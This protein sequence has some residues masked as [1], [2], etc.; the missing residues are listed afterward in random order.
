VLA[1][2]GLK[3]LCNT[4]ERKQGGLMITGGEVSGTFDACETKVLLRHRKDGIVLSKCNERK[5]LVYGV[6]V[7]FNTW[8]VSSC[9]R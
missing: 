3:Y 6:V 4:S 7:M 1:L 8:K 9:Q 5:I 2:A